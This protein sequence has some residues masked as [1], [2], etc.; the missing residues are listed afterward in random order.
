MI[1]AFAILIL[2]TALFFF[3]IQTLCD[4]ILRRELSRP[5]FREILG[6]IELD[7]PRVRK[8]L[9]VNAPTDYLQM[10]LALKC[11]FLALTYL[12]KNANPRRRRFSAQEKILV[13]YFRVLLFWLAFRHV[14]HF[15]EKECVIQLT[16][17]LRHFANL[18]GER[19]DSISAASVALSR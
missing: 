8:A 16:V 5:Y 2:S 17:I 18:V 4:K 19:I 14:L 9:S 11:D 10:R 12:V 13:V 6:A 7:Y 15:R 1:S 3:Y